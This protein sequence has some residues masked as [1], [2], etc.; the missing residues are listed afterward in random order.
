MLAKCMTTLKQRVFNPLTTKL[1]N[2]K[3]HPIEI[4]SR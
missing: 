2:L 4:V 1:F 3:F